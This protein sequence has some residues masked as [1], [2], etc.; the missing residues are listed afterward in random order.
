MWLAL[1]V[2]RPREFA[3]HDDCVTGG[4]LRGPLVQSAMGHAEERTGSVLAQEL[5]RN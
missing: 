3:R 4:W 5:D 2:A 1:K